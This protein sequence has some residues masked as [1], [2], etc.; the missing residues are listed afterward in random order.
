MFLHYISHHA[1]HRLC[2]QQ[3]C[4]TLRARRH[5]LQRA[6]ELVPHP[7]KILPQEP[8]GGVGDGAELLLHVL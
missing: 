7:L 6:Q 8:H 5:H 1:A 3:H 4:G 2:V